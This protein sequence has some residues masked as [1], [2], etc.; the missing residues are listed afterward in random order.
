MIGLGPLTGAL[1]LA[2][3]ITG[4][5][6]KVYSELW[7]GVDE[8]RY[9]Q[10]SSLGGGRLAT[11]LYGISPLASGHVLSFTLSSEERRVGKECCQYVLIWV[12]DVALNKKKNVKN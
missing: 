9:A 8:R 2:L 10:V 6:A 7:D 5:L 11:F 1:A 4:I 3:N 12:G